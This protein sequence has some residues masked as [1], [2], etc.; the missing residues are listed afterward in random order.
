MTQLQVAL[1]LLAVYRERCLV[2]AKG[3]YGIAW[4]RLLALP[5]PAYL[6]SEGVPSARTGS[7]KVGRSFAD[8]GGLGL[9]FETLGRCK[10][11][12]QDSSCRGCWSL[13]LSGLKCLASYC[14]ASNYLIRYLFAP[15]FRLASQRSPRAWNCRLSYPAKVSWSSWDS[16]PLSEPKMTVPSH[17]ELVMTATSMRSWHR[18]YIFNSDSLDAN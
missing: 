6:W 4:L 17:S 5:K 15:A 14:P 12:A 2:Q 13:R 16:H 8:D 7:W 11:C 18:C 3:A 10:S 1:S 9:Y